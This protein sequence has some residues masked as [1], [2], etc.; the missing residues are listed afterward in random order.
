MKIL[1]AGAWAWF[2]YEKAFA[3]A[4]SALG[5]EIIPF[6]FRLFF[7]GRFGYYQSAIPLPG[8]AMLSLNWALMRIGHERRPDVVLIWQG[9]HV[10]PETIERLREHGAITVSYCNDDPFGALTRSGVKWHQRCRWFWYLHGLRKFDIN[11]VYR[12]VNIEEAKEYGARKVAVM[13]P[14]FIPQKDRII[15]LSESERLRFGCDVVFIGHYEPDGREKYIKALVAAGIHVRL[16]GGKYWTREVLGECADCL[17]DIRPIYG[18]DYAKA[19]GGAS[20]CLAFLSKL[21]RDTYTRRCFEIPACGGLLLCERTSDLLEMFIEGEEAVFFS[22]PAELVEKTSWL[23]A[24]PSLRARISQAG[25]KRV[26]A[27]GHDVYS[28]SREFLKYLSVDPHSTRTV[29]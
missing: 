15:A 12:R 22:D 2:H 14:Y 29:V 17:G 8:P 24:N 20:L 26:W 13:K 28:R 25:M 4:L 6:R 3:N 21:N 11:L 10:L 16:F 18:T 19:L 7:E 23:M 9:V 5:H 1:I 27:D